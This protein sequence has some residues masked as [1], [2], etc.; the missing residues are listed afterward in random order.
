[1]TEPADEIPR[2]GFLQARDLMTQTLV[3]VPPDASLA[4]VADALAAA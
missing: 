3:S 2:G 4:E 1:M